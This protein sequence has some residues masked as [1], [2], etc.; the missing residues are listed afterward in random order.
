MT[1]PQTV[2]LLRTF[3]NVQGKQPKIIVMMTVTVMV[4]FTK[5]EVLL[6]F[7]FLS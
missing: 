2:L 4:T 6:D 1:F 7:I 3:N 5:Y